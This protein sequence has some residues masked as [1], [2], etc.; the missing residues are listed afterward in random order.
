ME[1]EEDSKKEIKD[2]NEDKSK[3][4]SIIGIMKANKKAWE[5]REKLDPK[6]RKP[7]V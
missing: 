7:W 5:E 2:K 3:D 1:K 6:D 4:F